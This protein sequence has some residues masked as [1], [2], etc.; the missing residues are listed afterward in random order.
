MAN[1]TD[2]TNIDALSEKELSIKFRDVEN[3]LQF[4][5]NTT[6]TL[7][8]FIKH[9]SL[10]LNEINAD[11]FKKDVDELNEKISSDKKTKKLHSVF[12]KYK[13]IILLFIE[14]FKK[15]LS[16]RE[17]ELK[18]IIDLLTKALSTV[19]KDNKI[20]NQ[21]IYEQSERIEKITLLD[22]I[23][24]I[25]CALKNEIENVRETIKKK[26]RYD[27][28]HLE[29]LSK[30][31]DILNLELEKAKADSL[32]DGLTGA[33]NRLAFDRHLKNPITFPLRLVLA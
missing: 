28:E 13:K 23:K 2:K 1:N 30:K 19:D 25:K 5:Q 18:G 4:F 29:K 15:H 22:D 7:L 3:R 10:D 20:F 21:K 9:F 17:D 14:K 8:V 27:R 12:Q 33:F 11:V 32:I 6:H 31:V 24:K 26:Q 16:D